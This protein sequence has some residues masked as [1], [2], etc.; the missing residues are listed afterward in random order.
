VSLPDRGI[1]YASGMLRC[2]ICDRPAGP[3]PDN[4]AFPF[5]SP[6]C[7]LVDLGK[8]LNEDYR[9]PVDDTSNEGG[10]EDPAPPGHPPP[11]E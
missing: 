4:R 11:Q 2:P 7:R 3:R 9:V 1:G 5:C 6:R 10:A 8:W